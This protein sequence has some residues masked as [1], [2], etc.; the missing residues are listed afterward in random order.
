MNI[1]KKVNRC[2]GYGLV[3]LTLMH[4]FQPLMATAI[5]VKNNDTQ[6]HNTSNVP[7]INIAKPNQAGISHNQFVDFNVTEKGAVLNNSTKAGQSQLAGQISANSNLNGTHA[8]LIINEVIGNGRS[9]LKG[10]TEI[11]GQQADILIAN[12]NGITCN[13]CGFINTKGITLTTGTPTFDKNG[14]IEALTTTQG[15]IVVGPK[16]MDVS[17]V[18]YTDIISRTVEL[19]GQINAQNLNVIQGSNKIDYATGSVTTANVQGIKPVVSIDTKALGGMYANK[20]HLVSTE[21]GVGVNLNNIVSTKN[22]IIL[23]ADGK[24]QLG[25]VTAKTNLSIKA[26]TLDI[27]NNKKVTSGGNIT[28]NADTVKNTQSQIISNKDMRIYADNII[29]TNAVI[30]ANDNLWIQKDVNDTRSHSLKNISGTIKTNNGD[31]L[32]RADSV[33]NQT[34]IKNI[35][36]KLEADSNS[37]LPILYGMEAFG[38]DDFEDNYTVRIL[39]AL[40][41]KGIYKWFG[42]TDASSKYD[43]NWVNI[44]RELFLIETDTIASIKSGKNLYINSNSLINDHGNI[45]SLVDIY[46]TGG[47]FHL[48]KNVLGTED[49]FLTYGVRTDLLDYIKRHTLYASWND[50][51]TS[52]DDDYMDLYY[53]VE[54]LGE[55]KTFSVKNDNFSQVSAGQNLVFDFKNDVDFSSHNYDSY[56]AVVNSEKKTHLRLVQAKISS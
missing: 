23:A 38:S 24:I 55:F 20:I 31:L 12:P 1:E 14:A 34:K 4:P 25:N 50:H 16:G 22:N 35:N 29:N 9:E 2:I 46:L 26:T 56:K 19:N 13:G 47:S 53:S 37:I 32:I 3:A 44:Q 10:K 43:T 52:S 5:T 49:L 54:K 28:I 45:S 21:N 39:P 6:I 18:D 11:F 17:N 41:E 30:E 48:K 33:E 7:I 51:L 36:Q 40:Y 27:T 15:M 8:K 42:T